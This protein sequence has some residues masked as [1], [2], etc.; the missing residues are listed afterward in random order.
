MDVCE[1]LYV[2][3][4]ECSGGGGMGLLVT[5]QHSNKSRSCC[6]K[7]QPLRL[8]FKCCLYSQRAGDTLQRG[9]RE[10]EEERLREEKGGSEVGWGVSGMRGK[11]GLWLKD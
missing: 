9:K 4:S 10:E 7:T 3:L 8:A 1:I 2:C 11:R 5:S 6:H